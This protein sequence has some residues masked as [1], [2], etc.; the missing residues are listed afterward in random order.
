MFISKICRWKKDLMF[1]VIYVNFIVEED[2]RKM[3]I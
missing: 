2:L 1:T 3:W